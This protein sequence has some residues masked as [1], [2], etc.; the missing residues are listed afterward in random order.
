MRK[1]FLFFGAII[2]F[3]LSIK[4]AEIFRL[5]TANRAIFDPA[6]QAEFFVGTTGKP[7]PSGTFGCVRGGGWQMHEGLDIRA[8][9]R[10]KRGE[11]LDP[12]LATAH[13][14]VVYFNARPSLSNYGNYIILRHFVDGLE[15]YSVYGHL[16]EIREGL[17]IG[18]L[19]KAGEII[20]L[21]GRTSNTQERISKERAHVHFELNFLVSDRFSDWQKKNSP[22][23]RND[24]GIWNGQNLI[25]LDPQL[26]LLLQKKEGFNLL[27]FV[28]NQTELCRVLVRATDFSWLKRYR[29]LVRRNPVAEKHGAAGY[30][31]ALNFNG[32]PFE[33][34]PRAA[35]E[36]KSKGRYKLL[37]VNAPEYKKNPCRRLIS[38]NGK[39]W[40]LASGGLHLLDLLTH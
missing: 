9:Q 33:L 6:R 31:I 1:W 19:V 39:S 23:Q 18:Q 35:S 3:S 34:V 21:M 14:T 29:L 5:P 40:V 7:W 8:T 16:R 13:G 32:L 17:K 38:P 12:I 15:I 36:I 37:S 20:G 30:E 4:A 27:N 26:I 2:I 28:Q 25:G 10:D 24:H 11:P 22:G